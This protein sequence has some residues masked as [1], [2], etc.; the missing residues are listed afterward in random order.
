M[1]QDYPFTGPSP[2][3]NQHI[4]TSSLPLARGNM[5][6]DIF[7]KDIN[8]IF[9]PYPL[10]CGVDSGMMNKKNQIQSKNFVF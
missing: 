10:E 4:Y 5:S 2:G 3:V 7:P 6:G 8:F 1:G 9:F